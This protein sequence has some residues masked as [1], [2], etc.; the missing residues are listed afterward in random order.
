MKFFFLFLFL[1][2]FFV[3]FQINS[4]TIPTNFDWRDIDGENYCTIIRQQHLPQWCGSCWCFSS[5][6]ALN[7]RFKIGYGNSRLDINVSPQHII[8]CGQAGN[9]DGGR[10]YLTY[11]FI[12]K[13]GV[14]DETC[15]PYE[16][17]NKE[18][19]P[20]NICKRCPGANQE[21]Y[22]V[23][24]PKKYFITSHGNVTG[25]AQ[26]LQ[27]VYLNGPVVCHLAVTQEL[28]EWNGGDKVFIDTTGR[29]NHDHY[30]SIVGFGYSVEQKVPYW[31]VRN[32]WGVEWNPS[33]SFGGGFFN[34]VRGV[35]NLDI[36]EMCFWAIPKLDDITK[37]KKK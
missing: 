13:N 14:V 33:S 8:N 16:A 32:S 36:E 37:F 11:D 25:E 3:F 21:C 34:L 10:P 4:I 17:K 12:Q 31:I 1:F 28:E 22:A 24:S 9:C 2:L 35:N 5:T 20:E 27:E 26:I 29:L 19:T 7:D 6:S 23:E 30:V 18:C 15:A